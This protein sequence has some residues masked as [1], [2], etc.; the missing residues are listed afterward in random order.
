MEIEHGYDAQ[1]AIARGFLKNQRFAPD[2][3]AG[4]GLV[5]HR[6][7]GIVAKNTDDDLLGLLREGI[8]GPF[9]KL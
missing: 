3:F 2:G 8:I 4:Q 1:V 9:H 5:E 6:T 7:E